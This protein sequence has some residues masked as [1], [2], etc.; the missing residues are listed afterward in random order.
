M[1]YTSKIN[2]EIKEIGKIEMENANLF[3][4]AEKN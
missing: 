2:K 4:I 3:E 1:E